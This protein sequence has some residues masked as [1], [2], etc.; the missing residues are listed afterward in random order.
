MKGPDGKRS[1]ERYR[2]LAP[3]YDASSV[4]GMAIREKTVALLHLQPGEVVVDMASGTGLSFALLT[5]AVGPNGRV[6]AI[7]HS[8]EMMALARRRVQASGWSNVTLIESAAQATDVPEF[9]A[10]LFHYAHDVLQSSAALA[11]LFARAK[12]GARVVVAG[13][14]FTSWWLAPLN[15]W[16]MVRA[17]PYLSTYAGLRQP[18][19]NLETYVP[20]LTIRPFLLDTGYIAHGRFQSGGE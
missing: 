7:E 11:R 2:R 17:R 20:D 4:T 5:K 14:K 9:D 16:V 15:L 12:P 10:V 13:A 1:I 6:V 3:S 18:W 19:R 8:P